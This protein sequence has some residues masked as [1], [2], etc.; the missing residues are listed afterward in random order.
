MKT[1]YHMK[2]ALTGGVER[3]Q[4]NQEQS[5]ELESKGY[6]SIRGCYN[7]FRENDIAYTEEE[8]KNMF[9]ELRIKKLQSLDKQVKKYS[10]IKFKIKKN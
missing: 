6:F 3:I 8:A 7:L 9:E 10:K 1:I 2:Y 4:L 5:E